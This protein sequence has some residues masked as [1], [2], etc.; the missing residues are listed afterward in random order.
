MPKDWSVR[1]ALDLIASGSIKDRQEGLELLTE[2]C[3][4]PANCQSLQNTPDGTGWLQVFQ[5]VFVLVK[6][7]RATALKSLK[8]SKGRS[9]VIPCTVFSIRST[10]TVV[11]LLTSCRCSFTSCGRKSPMARGSL[12][13]ISHDQTPCCPLLSPRTNDHSRW[14]TGRIHLNRL[15]QIPQ[16]PAQLS[17]SPGASRRAYMAIPH[18][19]HLGCRP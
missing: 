12:L 14:A 6:T 8:T 3:S 17:R 9:W 2:I 16:G 7:E 11:V 1:S 18:E 13:P 15:Y 19:Y 4:S 10:D 5:S